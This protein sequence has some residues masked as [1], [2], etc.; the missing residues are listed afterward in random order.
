VTVLDLSTVRPAAQAL[1]QPEPA[2]RFAQGI[3]TG[4]VGN[5]VTLLVGASP[6][7]VPGVPYA[8]SYYP[9]VNDSVVVGYFDDS[10][11][12]LCGLTIHSGWLSQDWSAAW[13][14][15]GE[16]EH[17]SDVGSITGTEVT[18]ITSASVTLLANRLYRIRGWVRTFSSTVAADAIGLR[19]KDG[20]TI[21][22]ETVA[23]S[24]QA[25]L[26]AACPAVEAI[27]TTGAGTTVDAAAISAGAHT[28][29]LKALRLAGTG[30]L[31]LGGAT[32]PMIL[33]VED[34]GPDGTP[35]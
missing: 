35:P 26:G 15:L 25:G 27:R 34:L 13:G 19:I 28:F 18:A 16:W 1:A 3:V 32:Y 4:I 9:V 5:T 21:L 14:L 11:F 8:A 22:S 6:L 17:S 10:P 33:S 20:A 7:P 12:V 29:T 23:D 2:P 30:T 31:T 24:V